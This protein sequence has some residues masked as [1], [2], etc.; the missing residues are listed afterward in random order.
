M[1]N[2][3]IKAQQHSH[4]FL[5]HRPKLYALVVGVGVVLFWR[6]IWHTIDNFHAMLIQYQQTSVIN[7]SN[8][9]WWDGPLSLV[10]GCVILYLT[11]SFISSFIGNELI[12]SGLRTEK[13]LAEKTDADVQSE[14]KAIAD[15]K[16]ELNQI[17]EK[18]EEL[19]TQVRD[20][21]VK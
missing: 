14:F 10:V 19:E 7:F 20:H 9:V 12:L 21:H 17:S 15:I 4:I 5:S 13:K 8:N 1:K 16:E 18:F 2:P 3:I 11:G 6:G